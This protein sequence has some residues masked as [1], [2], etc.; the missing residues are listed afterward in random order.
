MN[1]EFENGSRFISNFKYSLND[2]VSKDPFS[3]A[4]KNGILKFATIETSDYDKFKSE[5]N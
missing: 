2:D 4:K 3:E 1:V 5:C